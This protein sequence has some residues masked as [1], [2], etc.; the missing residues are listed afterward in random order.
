LFVMG[1]I[2][3]FIVQSI[4]DIR[5]ELLFDCHL[6]SDA[7]EEGWRTWTSVDINEFKTEG[8]LGC[9]LFMFFAFSSLFC[10]LFVSF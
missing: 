9:P 6:K 8:E 5:R 3:T 7:N 2:M 4:P 10:A 1:S